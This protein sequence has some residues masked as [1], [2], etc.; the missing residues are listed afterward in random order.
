MRLREPSAVESVCCAGSEA[1]I[2]QLVA[3]GLNLAEQFIALNETATGVLVCCGIRR[4]PC[5]IFY[6]VGIIGTCAWPN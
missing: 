6:T 1:H 2:E 4:R 5:C 3:Y